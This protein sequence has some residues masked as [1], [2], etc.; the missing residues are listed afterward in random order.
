MM[1]RLAGQ[2]GFWGKQHFLQVVVE[3]V[4][5]IL[6]NAISILPR[7]ANWVLVAT[8]GVLEAGFNAVHLLKVDVGKGPATKLDDFLEK[9]Q[10]GGRGSFSFSIQKFMLQI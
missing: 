9:C 3:A 8:I 6:C 2:C 1:R 5:L 4:D 10:R 7:V